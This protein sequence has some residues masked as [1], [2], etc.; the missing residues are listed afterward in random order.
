LLVCSVPHRPPRVARPRRGGEPIPKLLT[1]GL[2]CYA[3]YETA[4]G[5]HITVGA[6]E[7]KFFAQLCDLLG[8]PDLAAR[9]FDP[10]SQSEIATALAEAFAAKPLAD[11]LEVFDRED[12]SVGPVA[13]L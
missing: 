9:Q 11:W 10:S 3:I 7:T 5:R 12:V 6:L 4:D 1:G 13:T 8:L 2:A